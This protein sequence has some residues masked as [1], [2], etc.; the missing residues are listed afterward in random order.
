VN[1]HELTATDEEVVT[2]IVAL[3]A[4]NVSEEALAAWIRERIRKSTAEG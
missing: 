2:E 3:A 1:G 4:G